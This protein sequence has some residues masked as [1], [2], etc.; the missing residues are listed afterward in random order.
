MRHDRL[1]SEAFGVESP[2][3]VLDGCRVGQI[4]TACRQLRGD[5]FGRTPCRRVVEREVCRIGPPPTAVATTHIEG[6]DQAAAA[7]V[8][9]ASAADRKASSEGLLSV[10]RDATTTCVGSASAIGTVTRCG[11]VAGR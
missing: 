7:S 3:R 5:L 2:H 9:A 11:C 1:P 6:R 10:A 8:A 4:D